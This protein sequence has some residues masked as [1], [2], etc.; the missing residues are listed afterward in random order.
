MDFARDRKK[1]FTEAEF[2]EIELKARAEGLDLVEQMA[3]VLLD[4]GG[5]LKKQYDREKELLDQAKSFLRIAEIYLPKDEETIGGRMSKR[6]KDGFKA[7]VDGL[8]TGKLK[9]ELAKIHWEH[10]TPFEVSWKNNWAMMVIAASIADMLRKKGGDYWNNITCVMHYHQE[11]FDVTVQ[12]RSGKSVKDQLNEA[13]AKI[14]K[15]REGVEHIKKHELWG[16]TQACDDVLKFI[17]EG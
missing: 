16:V 6:V 13:E 10:G 2:E 4:T 15:I 3:A 8:R 14:R 1:A 11:Q 12:R 7:F 17:D 9:P 5:A